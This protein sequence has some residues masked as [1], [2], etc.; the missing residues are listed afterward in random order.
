MDDPSLTPIDPETL[1]FKIGP[2]HAGSRLDAFLASQVDGW[3]RARL[4]KLIESEDVLV[5]TRS[6]K[7][8]YKL[9]EGDDVEVELIA[10]LTVS[11]SPEDIPIDVVYEDDT[12]LVVNKPAGLVVHPA[13]GAPSG[14]L[15]NA[16]AY[17]FQQ[18]PDS[19]S[20]A[21][22]G[23]VHRLDRDTSGLLVV[24]KTEAALED[25]SD[26]FRSRTVFKSYVA[27]VHGRVLSNAGRIDQPL[28][29]DQSNRTRMA[30][31]RG[32][33]GSLTLYRVR[34]SFERFTLLDVE[35][36][37]GRTH[38]IRVHLAWLKHPVVG[39]ETYGAGRDNSIQDPRLRARVRH[40]KRQFL[41]AEKL[42]FTHPKTREFVEFQ[43]PLPIELAELLVALEEKS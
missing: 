39:D 25:L 38:Q 43:S 37:T 21:R 28:A 41:H 31:I 3:S 18:L 36:K 27:L 11:F 35:L 5:N 17:H 4:Q 9:H 30:V 6:A 12:L 2:A 42:A 1:S 13:A 29:R 19:G 16:L 20:G 10:P 32:G 22:P 34:R 14:T 23:I 15:A 26:Q 33:R 24:A 40:L 7:A 8:S